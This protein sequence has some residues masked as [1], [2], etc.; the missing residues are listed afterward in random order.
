MCTN[1]G[2]LGLIGLAMMICVR[3]LVYLSLYLYLGLEPLDVYFYETAIQKFSHNIMGATHLCA[4]N[5]T[6]V[7]GVCIPG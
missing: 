7:H 4:V 5:S 3:L 6:H 2:I 1:Q